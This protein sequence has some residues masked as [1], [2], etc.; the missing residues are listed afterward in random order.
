LIQLEALF[1]PAP[2]LETLNLNNPDIYGW[3]AA[4]LAAFNDGVNAHPLKALHLRNNSLE[5]AGKT[6]AALLGKFAHLEVLELSQADVKSAELAEVLPAVSRHQKLKMLLM[7]NLDKSHESAQSWS[8]LSSPTVQILE[9]WTTSFKGHWP[10]VQDMGKRLPAL[11]AL[12]LDGCELDTAAMTAFANGFRGHPLLRS[13]VVDLAP[14]T[15]TRR[16]APC[17]HLCS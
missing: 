4:A 14:T 9:M 2:E 13:L 16:L 10:L 6:L 5:G 1:S 15:L 11:T 7:G 17:C 12:R 3:D 8:T